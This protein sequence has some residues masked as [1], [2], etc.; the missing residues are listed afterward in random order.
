M[1]R[2]TVLAGAAAAVILL[3]C[4]MLNA[5]PRGESHAAAGPLT[6]AALSAIPK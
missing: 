5:D 2:I 4:V 3:G 6:V 1:T